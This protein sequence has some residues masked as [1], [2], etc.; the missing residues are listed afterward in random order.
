MSSSTNRAINAA[1]RDAAARGRF[2]T[3]PETSEANASMN[4]LIRG[5]P[6]P[7]QQQEPSPPAYHDAD[8]A[9]GRNQQLLFREPARMD[10]WIRG[11]RRGRQRIVAEEV[12]HAAG[13]PR[14]S[15]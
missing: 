5:E 8:A 4:R 10:D 14:V 3:L 2:T 13:D 12:E 6:P 15:W 11:Q 9:V 7:D 1:F